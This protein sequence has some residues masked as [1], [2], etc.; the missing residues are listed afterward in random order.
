[1]GGLLLAGLT[2][3]AGAQSLGDYARQQRAQKAATSAGAKVYTNDN[4]PTSGGLSEVGKASAP[5]AS[6]A[7]AS[8]DE[9]K[10]EDRGKQGEE[11]RA[12]AKELKDR[13]AMLQSEIQI[14][15]DELNWRPLTAALQY[16]KRI[17]EDDQKRRTEIADKEK[18]LAAERQKLED[19][20]DELRRKD[21]PRSWAD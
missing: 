10:P 19:L 7:S 6:S 15:K 5:A 3:L 21:L 1:M 14:R 11:Y 20:R 13:I 17:S 16:D 9:G 18:E 8:Q 4:L 2:A 12:R